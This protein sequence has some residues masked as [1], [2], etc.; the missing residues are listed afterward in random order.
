MYAFFDGVDVSEFCTKAPF[1]KHIDNDVVDTSTF[2]AADPLSTLSITRTE[3][4]AD[5]EGDLE[6]FFVVPNNQTYKFRTGTRKFKLTD[7]STNDLA[8]TTTSASA[9][10]TASGLLQSK[11]AQIISTQQIQIV[12]TDERIQQFRTGVITK[13]K[14]EYYD[15]LAQSFIIGDIPTGTYTTKID[16]YFKA[17][18][19]NVP[20]SVHLVTVENGIPTQKLVP[21]SKVVKKPKGGGTNHEVKISDDAS[22]ATTFEF[23]SPVYLSPGVEYAIVVMSNSPDYRL[24]MAEVGGD[25]VTTGTRISK[26]TYAGVSFKS[27]NASTWTPDQ[28]RDF[29]M[30]IHR[31]AFTGLS[32]Y[33][34]RLD[35]MFAG[36]EG[37]FSFSKLRLLSEEIDFA[38]TSIDYNLR[39]ESDS[40][41]LITP[42]DDKYFDTVRSFTSADTDGNINA[43]EAALNITFTSASELVSPAVDLDRL[44]LLAI[45]NIITDNATVQPGIAAT[46]TELVAGHGEG[47]ARYITREVELNNAADQLNILL[48]ANKPSSET[49]IRVYVRVK[50]TDERIRDVDFIKVEPQSPLLINSGNNFGETEYVFENTEPFTS[51]QV[52]IVF[53]S[54]NLALAPRVKDLRVIATI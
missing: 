54:E 2:D 17:R 1:V 12:D 18:S 35:P 52:K 11:E 50:S 47:S 42:D 7:S 5:N 32:G 22:V 27:Q 53:T 13:T 39:I 14:T 28:N 25:D 24:W 9:A 21:F 41:V 10:Y 45:E 16:L 36:G 49:D 8:N 44:S 46:D 30:V 6:G 15:P 19:E 51:F 38:N 26:N 4:I 31:A 43:G 20:L 23:E 40:D 29:K 34:Y 3:L 37:A 33:T 48:L